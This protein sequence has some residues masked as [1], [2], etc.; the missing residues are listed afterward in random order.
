MIN[1]REEGEFG[2]GATMVAIPKEKPRFIECCQAEHDER[3]DPPVNLLDATIAAGIRPSLNTVAALVC[4]A[5]ASSTSL[6]S[7]RV[8]NEHQQAAE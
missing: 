4:A 8:S 3:L 1:F 7:E 5:V 2:D 6:G